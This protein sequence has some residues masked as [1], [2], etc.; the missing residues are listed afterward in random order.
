MHV[1]ALIQLAHAVAALKRNLKRDKRACFW[2]LRLS[3][4]S[5][6]ISALPTCQPFVLFV[7]KVTQILET[8]T[9]ILL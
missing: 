8:C 5:Y 7:P 1:T 9:Y 2:S 4:S 3:A 6:T